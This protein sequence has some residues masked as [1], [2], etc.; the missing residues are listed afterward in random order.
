MRKGLIIFAFLLTATSIMANDFV[1][2]ALKQISFSKKDFADTIKVKV[3]DG[4]VLIPVEID[5]ITKHFLLDTGAQ[6]GMW[7]GN[8]ESWMRPMSNDTVNISDSNNQERMQVI[9]Q[10]KSIKLGGLTI[11][12][13]PLVMGNLGGYTC[14]RFDGAFGFDLTGKGLSFKVDTKDSLLIVTDRKRFF[15]EEEKDSPFMKYKLLYDTK[16]VVVLESPI[17][18]VTVL[19]DTC[20]LNKWVE[21][22]QSV[23]NRFLERYPKKDKDLD[24]MT[25]YKGTTINSAFGLHGLT[26][27]TLE[28][29]II[30]FSSIKAGSLTLNDLY[31]STAC[32]SLLIGSALLK[33]ASLIIDSP[34]K[35]FVFLPHDGQKEITVGNKD[36]NGHTFLPTEPG[37]PHGVFTVLVRE[38]STAYQKG[39][40]TGD[41]LLEVD[42][43]PITDVCTFS[44]MES[45][46]K[47]TPMKFRS[48]DGTVKQVTLIR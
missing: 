1:K 45:S 44:R 7:F 48:P 27:D 18:P 16:P 37:D 32:H 21:L 42:G 14:D 13:Y 35:R 20:A 12:N 6:L 9:Y 24:A 17:G 40:R 33:H 34:K 41:Y 11:N 29:R 36:I 23:L 38:G 19:F 22:P 2:T 5:G 25:I 8:K 46:G 15:A 43:I 30:R 47:E 26:K 31:V 39:L 10:G 3:V 4:I 28:E